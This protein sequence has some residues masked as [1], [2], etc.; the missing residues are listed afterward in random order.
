M[1]KKYIINLVNY[2]N[3]P[4]RIWIF[5]AKPGGIKACEAFANSSAF[6]DINADHTALNKITI[7]EQYSLHLGSSTQALMSGVEIK[8]IT[9]LDV[10][11]NKEYVADFVTAPTS[12]GPE[13][14]L[15][16]VGKCTENTL[17]FRVNPFDVAANESKQCYAN[18]SFGIQSSLSFL[19]VTWSPSP[20]ETKK[21]KPKLGFYLS[22]GNYESN[23]LV[24]FN[25]FEKLPAIIPLS[26]F[27]N[28]EVTVT[29]TLDKGWI[30]TAGK[31]EPT[32]L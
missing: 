17:S 2:T 21:I 11:F 4:H 23:T 5:L 29:L 24:D 7:P 1:K 10:E 15:N 27:I 6:I 19:G 32:V 16:K 26:M 12:I 14:T 31:P 18:A 13:L 25:T 22:T 9:G 8:H 20:N 30:V 3:A 28:N